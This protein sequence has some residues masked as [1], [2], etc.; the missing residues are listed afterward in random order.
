VAR[1]DVLFAIE[2]M[3]METAVHAERAG[4]VQRIVSQAGVTVE[5]KDLMMEFADEF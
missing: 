4:I 3:K 5:A 1:G 2:A